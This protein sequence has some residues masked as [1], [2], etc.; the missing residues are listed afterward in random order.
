MTYILLVFLPLLILTFYE[1]RC[2]CSTQE[3][4]IYKI[5][6]ENKIIL[7]I[8]IFFSIV[9]GLQYGVGTDYFDYFDF[10]SGKASLTRFIR[11][12]EYFLV[13]LSLFLVNNRLSPQLGF[14]IVSFIQNIFMYTFIKRLKLKKKF[15]WLYLYLTYCTFFYNQINGIRQ[16]VAACFLFI[17][18]NLFLKK[19]FILWLIL[20]CMGFMFH[21]SVFFAIPI[22]FSIH[23][24]SMYEKSS[25][26]VFVLLG[27]FILS[28][29]DFA[30]FVFSVLP[31][32]FPYAHYVTNDYSYEGISLLN[33]ITKYVY[34][35]YFLLSIRFLKISD[36]TLE[37]YLFKFGFICF[38]FKLAALSTP[39]LNRMNL[40]FEIYTI[41]PLYYY[42][43]DIFLKDS[44]LSNFKTFFYFVF[45]LIT[46][47]GIVLKLTVFSSKEYAYQSILY[48]NFLGF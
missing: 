1:N 5:R 40:Y 48:Q 18:F 17:I 35:P 25:F 38:C 2:L 24:V 46:M 34:I 16:A 41:F 14:V 21:K 43:S 4:S 28:L 20:A 8:F 26:Y 30:E 44:R 23:I 10:F 47:G 45:I 37:K 7:I 27:A 32:N 11:L 12:K 3:L 15:L 39:I 36:N 29:F 31:S 9:Q 6:E 19:R 22:Y 42:F 33:K 13:I